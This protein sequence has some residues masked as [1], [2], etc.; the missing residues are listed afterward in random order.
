MRK[1]INLFGIVLVLATGIVYAEA[2]FDFEELME[3][4]D[5]NSRNLQ[6]SISNKDANASIDLAK[7]MQSDFKLVEGFFEKRGNAAD[8]VTDAKKY[9]DLAVEVVKFVEANDFDAA[10]NKALELTK[11]CDNACHD[12][13]KPL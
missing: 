1:T 13:Y 11:N 9:E 6:G 5:T 2:A 4:I 8:A 10:S 12:T 3:T 7:K